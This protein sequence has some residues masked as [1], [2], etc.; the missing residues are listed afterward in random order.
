VT[1]QI[2]RIRP[3]DALAVRNLRLRALATDPL[4]FGSTYEREVSRPDDTWISLA[5]ERASSTDRATFLALDNDALLGLV[6]TGRDE[7]NPQVFG[8]YSVWVAPAARNRGIGSNLMATSEAWAI[9]QGAKI[10]KL[11]V[12]DSAMPARRLYERAG[13]V[14]DGRTEPSPHCGVVE[15][16]MTKALSSS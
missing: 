15:L 3:E 6:V 12:S 13:F 2:R 16:G 8:V 9:E 5:T 7:E 14:F 11:L 10:L 1:V 4:S